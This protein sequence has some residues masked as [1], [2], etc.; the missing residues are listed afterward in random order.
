M[1]EMTINRNYE[2]NCQM[3]AIKVIPHQLTY[4]IQQEG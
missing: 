2:N 4:Q 1:I 3:D